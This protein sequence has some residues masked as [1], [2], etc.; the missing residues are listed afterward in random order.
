MITAEDLSIGEK[1]FLLKYYSTPDVLAAIDPSD[2]L[3]CDS[4]KQKRVIG[5]AFTDPDTGWKFYLTGEVGA[6]IAQELRAL[7]TR[8]KQLLSMYYFRRELDTARTHLDLYHIHLEKASQM[9]PG[10][11]PN[12]DNSPAWSFALSNL[13]D[14]SEG[15]L[16][17]W[18][19][20]GCD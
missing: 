19:E 12:A 9:L 10:I 8:D 7:G 20:A 18:L 3:L 4:L 6:P 5:R 14:M 17:D 13:S 15:D 2:T 11:M 16:L 1:A